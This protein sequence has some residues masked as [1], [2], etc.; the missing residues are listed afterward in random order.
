[1][2]NSKYNEINI[3]D[4][5]D[6]RIDEGV[7]NANLEKI[8][9]NRRKRNMAIGHTEYERNKSWIFHTSR[10]KKRTFPYSIYEYG[11]FSRR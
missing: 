7:K 4:N 10:R 5:L 1:M 3:P 11:F 6:E 8:K 2:N 9:N